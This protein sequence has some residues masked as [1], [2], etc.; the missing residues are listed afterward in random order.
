MNILAACLFG[1]SVGVPCVVLEEWLLGESFRRAPRSAPGWHTLATIGVIYIGWAFIRWWSSQSESQVFHGASLYAA[2][3]YAAVHSDV[4]LFTLK[5]K[6]TDGRTSR[7]VLRLW[8]L[9][10]HAICPMVAAALLLTL[11]SVVLNNA[12]NGL[13][14]HGMTLTLMS[15]VLCSTHFFRVA[16]VRSRHGRDYE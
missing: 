15:G 5:H 7:W 12:D 8:R 14:R 11:M 2:M 9:R 6:S 10:Q 16:Y 3:I 1:A 4:L 13:G